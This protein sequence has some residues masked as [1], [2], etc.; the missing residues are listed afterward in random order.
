MPA[1]S[2][3]APVHT[4][5]PAAVRA[6]QPSVPVVLGDR[7]VAQVQARAVETVTALVL[8]HRHSWAA[9]ASPEP[10]VQV[11]TPAIDV[12]DR[13]ARLACAGGARCV[14]TPGEV[15]CGFEV[16]VIDESWIVAAAQVQ[17]SHAVTPFAMATICRADTRCTRGSLAIRWTCV[18][19][20]S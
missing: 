6:D 12:G 5:E 17:E 15:L 7:R 2:G 14:D 1:A 9:P 3:F 10:Q 18:F 16:L 20:T 11:H 13:V 19:G 8:D 4:L